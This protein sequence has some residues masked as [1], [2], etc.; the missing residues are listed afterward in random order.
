ML[1]Q[2]T[3]RA[4]PA[5]WDRDA[6]GPLIVGCHRLRGRI[7]CYLIQAVTLGASLFLTTSSVVDASAYSRVLTNWGS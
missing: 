1:I 2:R 5:N 6:K 7:L 4:G 3:E